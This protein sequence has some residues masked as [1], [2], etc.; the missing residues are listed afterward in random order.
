MVPRNVRLPYEILLIDA[1]LS[2]ALIQI[3][4][5]SNKLN[6]LIDFIFDALLSMGLIQINRISNKLNRLIDLIFVSPDFGIKSCCRNIP[7][8][9]CDT[10]HQ[11]LLLYFSN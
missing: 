5:I 8:S 7:L 1:L 4:R 10:H 9:E 11:P 3:N 2:M 6:R